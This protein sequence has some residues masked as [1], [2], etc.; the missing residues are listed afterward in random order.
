MVSS[1]YFLPEYYLK[2]V[3]NKTQPYRF[4]TRT[5]DSS[6]KNRIIEYKLI[7]EVELTYMGKRKEIFVYHVLTT[8][9][10]IKSDQTVKNEKFLKENVFAFG[11]IVL[12][13]NEK[14]EIVKVYNLNEMEDRWIK[15]VYALRE[16]SSGYEFDVFVDDISNVLRDEEKTLFFLNSKNML[17]LYFHGLFGKNDIKET[18]K[19]R[20]AAIMEFDDV[21]VT[22]EILTDKKGPKFIITAQKSNN[23]ER[24]ISSNDI[25]KKYE[26]KLLYD[27]NNQLLD[28]FLEIENENKNIKHSLVWVG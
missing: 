22:E 19:K 3:L 27:K 7:R 1:T 11:I 14:G 13:V 2:P 24:V 12:G 8:R 10:A 5:I 26:G 23:G 28:G 20:P 6:N 18:P 17:G 21:I 16:H 9:V 25:V 4:T 15:R